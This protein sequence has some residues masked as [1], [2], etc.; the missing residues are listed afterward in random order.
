MTGLSG[1]E[2][3]AIDAEKP[4]ADVEMETVRE[5]LRRKFV[6]PA[7]RLCHQTLLHLR[8]AALAKQLLSL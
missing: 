3:P 8:A 7:Q 4:L 1:G 6:F 2:C 5:E